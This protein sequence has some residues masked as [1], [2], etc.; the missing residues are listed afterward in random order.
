MHITV[1]DEIGTK[2][3]PKCAIKKRKKQK[4]NEA[5]ECMWNSKLTM[6]TP[7]EFAT[8]AVIENATETTQV[9]NLITGQR[10]NRV[11]LCKASLS[12]S[13]YLILYLVR[14]ISSFYLFTFYFF[15]HEGGW[16]EG[17]YA[18]FTMYARCALFGGKWR[19]HLKKLAGDAECRIFSGRLITS[20]IHHHCH[21]F[22]LY[23]FVLL[24]Y[25]LQAISFW[26]GCSELRRQNVMM[27]VWLV[28]RSTAIKDGLLTNKLRSK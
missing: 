1:I 16:E 17:M 28:G 18:Y 5:E 23:I 15:P 4:K 14:H 21:F 20:P 2:W 8:V 6:L 27:V 24:L 11:L 3:R 19:W 7:A 25:H 9:H 13:L 10:M 22:F 26:C 12:L